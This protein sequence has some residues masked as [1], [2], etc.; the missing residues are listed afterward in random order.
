MATKVQWFT[1]P[2]GSVRWRH[3]VR[4]LVAAG[5]ALALG[6]VT[7]AFAAERSLV[8]IS[9][10]PFTN[11]T[12]QHRT[13]VEPDTFSAGETMVSAFQVGRFF[14]GGA[15]DI[16]FATTHDGGHR[17]VHGFLPGV[18]VFSTPAGPYARASDASVAFDLRHRT[19]LVSYLGILDTGVVDVLAS[20]SRDGVHWGMPV[21][22]AR[23]NTFLD[24][25][26]TVCDNSRRSRFF[27]NCYTEFDIASQRDLEQMTTS[28]DGG[29]TWG[30][31]KATAD[32]VHGIGGQPLVQP[33]GRVVVPFNGAGP[34]RGSVRAFTSDDGGGSWNAS[35][36][37]SPLTAH[38][39][40]GGLR[41]PSL[42]SAEMD[43]QGR[44][45]LAWQDCRFEAGC[46]ANDIVL[47]TSTDGTAWSPV[48]RIPIDAVGSGVDHFTPG[49]GVDR[50]SAGDRTRLALTYYF[51]PA[52]DCTAATC[53]LQV[54][55]VSSTSG[56]RTWTRPERLAGPMQL[57]WLPATSQGVMVADYISTSFVEED[58][59]LGVF[60][61]AS[62]P[63]AANVF[64]QPMFS[65]REEVRGGHVPALDDPVLFTGGGAPGGGQEAPIA[66]QTAF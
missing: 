48:R 39:V 17:F 41:A 25:N 34:N 43:H 15:S 62:A 57:S 36:V 27:G 58:D 59:A 42:P 9:E 16:G 46:S 33:D 21:A 22:V 6:S 23:L 32:A 61:V 47:S 40:A 51:Y 49:I 45:F 2:R 26:W 19:W 64:D 29:R 31:P 7:Q 4:G 8:R 14:N 50:F 12:S 1:R 35:V 54:G 52:A 3:A 37:V 28:T 38:R 24:K 11:A 10:D 66:E 53:Q 44:V 13:E 30:A 63:E 65:A 55:F 5:A 18:T 60:A 20:G 56:G